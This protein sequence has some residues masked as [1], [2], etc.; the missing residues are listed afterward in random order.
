M[1]YLSILA[2]SFFAT[3]SLTSPVARQTAAQCPSGGSGNAMNFSLIAVSKADVSMQWAL[4]VESNGGT[5]LPGSDGFLAVSTI[6]LASFFR[7]FRF[8][9]E[10]M[11]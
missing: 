5:S 9:R 8:A 1:F 3:L 10:L 11:R 4:A 7:L 6:F 2:V